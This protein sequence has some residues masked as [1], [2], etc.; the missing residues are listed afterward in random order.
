L[1]IDKRARGNV[2]ECDVALLDAKRDL[3]T[4]QSEH[5]GSADDIRLMLDLPA[6]AIALVRIS[7]PNE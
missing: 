6:P 2:T 5:F 4:V 3:K 7:S 1:H